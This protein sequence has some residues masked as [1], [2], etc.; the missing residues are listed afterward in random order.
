MQVLE[1]N[2]GPL[3]KQ[4]SAFNHWAIS[5]AYKNIFTTYS[6]SRKG[7]ALGLSLSLYLFFF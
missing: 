4:K 6:N 5:P 1:L 2:L 7:H 3:Q